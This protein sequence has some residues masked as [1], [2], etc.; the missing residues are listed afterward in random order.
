MTHQWSFILAAL[1]LSG[2]MSGHGSFKDLENAPT[3]TTFSKLRG[4]Y[5]FQAGDTLHVYIHRNKRMSGNFRV[6][7]SGYVHIPKIGPVYAKNRTASLIRTAIQLKLKPI[8]RYATVDVTNGY[9]SSYQVIFSGG[10]KRPGT[11]RYDYKTS[12]L[13]GLARAGGVRSKNSRVILIRTIG[14][15]KHRYESSFKKILEGRDN[16]D[17]VI[18]ERGDMVFVD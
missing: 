18:L 10:V 7:A 11:Y 4:Q 8:L 1:I 5:L 6:G 3:G 2:C 14:T 9:L 16:F 15:K 12:L 17:H 13:E